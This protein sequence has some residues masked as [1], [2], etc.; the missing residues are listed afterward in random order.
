LGFAIAERILGEPGD[1]DAKH[2]QNILQNGMAEAPGLRLNIHPNDLQALKTIMIDSG[3]EWTSRMEMLLKANG[4]LQPGEV[5]VEDHTGL[6]DGG[7][8]QTLSRHFNPPTSPSSDHA[9][10]LASTK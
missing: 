2:L 3:L 9:V 4:A 1:V 10:D 7:I 8:L 5:R 6:M